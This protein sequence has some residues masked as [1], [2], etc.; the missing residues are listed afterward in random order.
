MPPEWAAYT[1]TGDSS[2]QTSFESD[3]PLCTPTY[4]C[5]ASPALPS[6]G[7]LCAFTDAD[8]VAMSYKTEYSQAVE[9]GFNGDMSDQVTMTEVPPGTYSITLTATIPSESITHTFSITFVDPC[10]STVPTGQYA[11]LPSPVLYGINDPVLTDIISM[12]DAVSSS[13]SP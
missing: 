2:Y 12:T 9:W 1:Y 11:S 10:P 7:D 13:H 3:Q 6:G 4:A 8:S 5:S